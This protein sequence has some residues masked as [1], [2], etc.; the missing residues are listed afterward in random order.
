MKEPISCAKAKKSAYRGIKKTLA[1]RIDGEL[2]DAFHDIAKQNGMCATGVL[3]GFVEAYC[4]PV[5]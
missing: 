4:D 2:H 1:I 5:V 3:R